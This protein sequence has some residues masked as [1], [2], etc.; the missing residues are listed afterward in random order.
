MVT[1]SGHADAGD[2]RDHHSR[3]DRCRAAQAAL[4]LPSRRVQRRSL[5][6]RARLG[7]DRAAR[8]GRGLGALVRRPHW[9]SL[10][11]RGS[12]TLTHQTSAVSPTPM[13]ES[14]LRLEAST[15]PACRVSCLAA[16]E[17]AG[18]VTTMALANAAVRYLCLWDRATTSLGELGDGRVLPRA[19]RRSVSCAPRKPS[20]LIGTA[21]NVAPTNR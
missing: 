13:G 12:W 2:V 15:C 7:F 5:P 20:E 3:R 1:A 9:Q 10:R 19:G 4:A 11:Q 14:G 21:A 16:W 18:C 6:W 8:Q 17:D